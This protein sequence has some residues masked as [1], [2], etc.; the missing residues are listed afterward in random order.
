MD[1]HTPGFLFQKLAPDFDRALTLIRADYVLDFVAGARRA[2]DGEPVFAG[3]VAA[4][5]EDV[6]YLAVLQFI[7]ERDNPPVDSRAS[8]RVAHFRMNGVSEIDR[9]GAGRQNDYAAFGSEAVNLI[10]YQFQCQSGLKL[11]RLAH[12]ALPF[13]KLPQPGDALIVLHSPP[14]FFVLP[15]RRNAF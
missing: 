9:G 12:F 2:N 8:A 1:A 11:L 14:A 10:R 6:N 5:G 15:A 13:D 7:F 3:L 4:L